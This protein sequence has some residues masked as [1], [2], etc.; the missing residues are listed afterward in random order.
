MLKWLLKWWVRTS[1]WWLEFAQLF[2]FIMIEYIFPFALI[3]FA[4]WFTLI[5]IG[6]F[7]FDGKDNKKIELERKFTNFCLIPLWLLW[8]IERL[9]WW[10]MSTK[11]AWLILLTIIFTYITFL[12]F[13]YILSFFVKEWYKFWDF[14]TN[15][16]WWFSIIT[17]FIISF[18]II[19]WIPFLTI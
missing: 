9:M 1:E 7:Y 13:F 10:W 16:I 11:I 15:L 2:N 6:P 18:E 19:F 4:L 17:S 14:T 12:W 5:M 3:V 8:F